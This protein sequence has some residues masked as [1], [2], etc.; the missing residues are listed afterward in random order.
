MTPLLRDR[1]VTVIL[2]VDARDSTV[3]MLWD[4]PQVQGLAPDVEDVSYVEGVE[5]LFGAVTERARQ[6]RGRRL[7]ATVDTDEYVVPRTGL[8]AQLGIVVRNDPHGV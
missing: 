1:L 3:Q 5:D 7:M 6:C 8:E 4:Q 2:D